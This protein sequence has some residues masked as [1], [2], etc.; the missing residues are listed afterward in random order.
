MGKTCS[1]EPSR[2]GNPPVIK[3][4]PKPGRKQRVRNLYCRG[5]DNFF[6]S[7]A[8]ADNQT[9]ERNCKSIYDCLQ[10]TASRQG[11]QTWFKSVAADP[12]QLQTMIKMYDQKNPVDKNS[13]RRNQ[14]ITGKTFFA[15]MK[16]QFEASTLVDRSETGEMRTEEEYLEWVTSRPPSKRLSLDKARIE[17]SKMLETKEERVWDT[18]SE[19]QVRLWVKT[20]DTVTFSNQ[21]KR[22]QMVSVDGTQMK[23]QLKR[24]SRR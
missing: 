17:W 16:T 2:D 9:L 14:C 18:T 12:T 24:S 11:Q 20:A 8:F 19:G 3:K 1:P 6:P 23:M 13:S 5:C 22:S 21:T 7:A 15:Q 4:N 10:K